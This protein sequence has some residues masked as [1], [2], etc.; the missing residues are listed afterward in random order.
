MNRLLLSRFNKG[1]E[2]TK[3]VDFI[4]NSANRPST[5]VLAAAQKVAII[6]LLS[7]AA[8][9]TAQ[10]GKVEDKA[11]S[12]SYG[13][14]LTAEGGY[15]ITIDMPIKK[16]KKVVGYNRV[17]NAL[18][19][20]TD[21]FHNEDTVTIV[22][23]ATGQ[24][25]S[26][27]SHDINAKIPVIT[28][29]G[30]DSRFHKDVLNLSQDQIKK[31]YRANY[32]SDNL[33]KAGKGVAQIAFDIGVNQGVDTRNKMLA[34]VVSDLSN[35]EINPD[36]GLSRADVAVIAGINKK[37]PGAIEY[38]LSVY[39]KERY[40]ELVKQSRHKQNKNGWLNRAE[41][42][43][44]IAGPQGEKNYNDLLANA[45]MG[46]EALRAQEASETT[47]ENQ[48]DFSE[49]GMQSTTTESQSFLNKVTMEGYQF[50]PADYPDIQ[51]QD[52]PSHGM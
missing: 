21:V 22:N 30:V 4:G 48:P 7:I 13:K 16:G 38:G 3:E 25:I 51:I 5:S 10:A 28:N 20:D 14:T 44:K 36:T 35:Y 18:S 52:S 6:S 37:N 47:L 11:F 23:K 27:A 8:L 29:A 46:R 39:A 32:W 9:G 42:Y 41:S 1:L 24:S 19:K 12:D 26:L 33:V 45:N 43:A 2:S 50:N 17:F 40:Q 15:R 34:K 31:L 49:T